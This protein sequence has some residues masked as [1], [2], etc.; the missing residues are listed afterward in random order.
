MDWQ[1][2]FTTFADLLEFGRRG[3][4]DSVAMADP[5]K[6]RYVRYDGLAD[7]VDRFSG[8]IN[9][10]FDTDD[11]FVVSVFGE[12]SMEW[13]LVFL[14]AVAGGNIIA[15]LNHQI[16]DPAEIRRLVALSETKLVYV[17]RQFMELFGRVVRDWPPG[18]EIGAPVVACMEDACAPVLAE[19]MERGKRAEVASPS[20]GAGRGKQVDV[21]SPP[22]GAVSGA[23][24]SV[25]PDDY[26]ILMYTSG[27]IKTK[28]VMHSQ[29]SLLS[30]QQSAAELLLVD[31][32]NEVFIAGLPLSHTYGLLCGFVP[33]CYGSTAVYAPTPRAIADCIS[34]S[35]EAFPGKGLLAA[36]VPE[37]ARIMNKRILRSARSAGGGKKQSLAKLVLGSM[38]YAAFL[39]MRRINYFTSSKMGLDLSGLFFKAIKQRFGDELKLPIGGGP[40][41]KATEFGLRGVGILALGG[42]GTTEMAPLVAA[43]VPR[44]GC[45]QPGTVGQVPA[46]MEAAIVD[47]EVCCRGPNMMLGYLKNEE[48]TKKAMPG[49]GWY[50]TGDKGYFARRAFG[51]KLA[52]AKKPKGYIFTRSDDDCYLVLKGRVD[53]QFANHRGENIFP[54][55]I[56]TL[57]MNYP[58]VDSCRVFESPP[59]CVKAEIFPDADALALKLGRPPTPDDAKQA[60]SQVVKQVNLHLMSGCGIDS[61]KVVDADFERNPFGKIKRK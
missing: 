35:G 45:M 22:E 29:R 25:G 56:E 15:P 28:G 50:H 40:T 54:E 33:L 36:A 16:K 37:L 57:L 17:S 58:A 2:K 55:M 23:K 1:Q 30:N 3:Y 26:A 46:G 59:S 32:P 42:Y 51:G 34:A 39:L 31:H 47:G 12:N 14:S 5:A 4:P 43:G 13:M 27:S 18:Y 52:P 20:E 48:A 19:S 38:K 60:I 53:N 7:A 44:H 24:K 21:A 9:G 8:R 10:M 11:R 61:F 49:D 41:D 6:G